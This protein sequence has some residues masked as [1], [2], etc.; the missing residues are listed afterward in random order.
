MPPASR[1]EFRP[2]ALL[3]ISEATD[4]YLAVSPR[5]AEGFVA[6]LRG[7]LAK[8]REAPDRWPL[9]GGAD[10]RRCRLDGFPHMVVYRIMEGTAVQILAVAHAKRRPGYWKNR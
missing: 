7:C 8:I 10:G 6:D 4:W 1:L 9:V 5:A 2:A 3:E